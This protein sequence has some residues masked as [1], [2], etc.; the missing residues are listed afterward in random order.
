VGSVGKG[1]SGFRSDERAARYLQLYDRTVEEN[2]PVEHDELDLPSRF[3]ITHVRVS[4]T[5]QGVPL[6]LVHPTT[7][8]SAGWYPLIGTLCAAER[9]VYTPD[10]IGGAGRSVHTAPI[11]TGADLATWL[12]EVLDGLEL[13]RVHLMGYSEGGWIAASHAAGSNRPERLASL[14][15]IEPAGAIT[16]VPARFLAG[17]VLR[18]MRVMLSRD[19]PA[20]VRRFNRWM[21]GEV[22]LTDAQVELIEAAIGSFQQRLPTPSPLSDEQ[23]R[24]ITAPTLLVL[25]ADSRLHDAA[26][27]RDRAQML[28]PD[29]TVDMIADAGHGVGFQHPQQVAARLLAHARA[30]EPEH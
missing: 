15:L 1:V 3:G 29:V 6:L 21:N 17:M 23:L 25:G 11:A 16:A 2:W 5:G 18:G 24:A 30:H 13:D 7:G 10:T 19:K 22:E 28:L 27:V 9:R 12:D 4:G 26:A 14:A 20:A 8:S